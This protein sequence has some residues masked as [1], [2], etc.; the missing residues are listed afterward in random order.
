VDAQDLVLRRGTWRQRDQPLR[1]RG[2]LG[3]H[4]GQSFGS[5]GVSR[6]RP[7]VAKAPIFDD[8][9]AAPGTHR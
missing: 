3:G 6:R 4:G 1:T 9:D 5:L 2:D 8:G 7:V